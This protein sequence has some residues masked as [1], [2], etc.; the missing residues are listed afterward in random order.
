MKRLCLALLLPLLLAACSTLSL[1][2]NQLPRL[3][4]W[5]IDGYLDLDSAQSAQLDA[6]LR[7]L[8]GW[9]RREELP[10]WRALLSEAERLWDG[11]VTAAK[12]DAL[13]LEAAASVERTL[14][15]A[16][17]LATPLLAS[18]RPAQWER[19]QRR[20]RERLDEWK[21]RQLEDD[22]AEQRGERFTTNLSR[23]LGDLERPLRQQALRE[24]AAWPSEP[25]RLAGEWAARQRLTLDG[26]RAWSRGE[27][28]AGLRLLLAAGGRDD[29]PG[30]AL[31]PA[32]RA[33]RDAVEAS[34]VKLMNAAS[35]AQRERARARWA[36]WRQDLEQ[37]EKQR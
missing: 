14:A 6:G 21:E 35:A 3:A 25:D 23:W 24:A 19:L 17:P 5:W 1:G 30:G 27:Q 4:A 33:R 12:L 29:V 37:L 26:L 34:T 20:L 15:Q 28:A 16:G 13:Q 18:L 10:R 9:H 22:A 32:E 36:A 31:A 7:Q 2:Y 11:P 8:H